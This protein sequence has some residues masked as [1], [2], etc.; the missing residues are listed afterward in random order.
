MN[1]VGP[2]ETGT[3]IVAMEVLIPAVA[4]NDSRMY[5]KGEPAIQA[6]AEKGTKGGN[7]DG[8]SNA[9]TKGKGGRQGKQWLQCHSYH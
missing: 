8:Y 4:E 2:E 3:D 7:R 9:G 1:V 6:L 5:K